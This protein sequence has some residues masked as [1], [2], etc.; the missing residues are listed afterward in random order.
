MIF[1]DSVASAPVSC[2]LAT[3]TP[4]GWFDPGSTMSEP[5]CTSSPPLGQRLVRGVATARA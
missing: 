5:A 4:T 2:S 3:T 1:R